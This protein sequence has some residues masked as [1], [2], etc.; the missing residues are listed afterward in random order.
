MEREGVAVRPGLEFDS[1]FPAP[2][3]EDSSV[4]QN[5]GVEDTMQLII[6]TVPQTLWH[7]EKIA[8]RLKGKDLYSTCRNIWNFVYQHIKYKRDKDG[9]EQVRSPRRTWWERKTGVDCDCYTEF[10]S[11]ILYNL[12]IPHV[13][14]ITKY[15]KVSPEVPTW[16]HVY[17]VVPKSGNL[18]DTNYRDGYIVLDCV[19][20][21]F[22]DE[23]PFYEK[24]DYKMR[25]DYLDGFDDEEQ[26]VEVT[27]EYE[28]DRDHEYETVE[29]Q[30]IAAL[31]GDLGFLK[32]L[33]KKVGS[34]VKKTA[35]KVGT[36]VKKAAKVVAD[37]AGDVIR[38]VNR[39]VNPVTILLRNGFLLIMK[40]N[41]FNIAGR[42]RYAYLSDA[43]ATAMN[44]NLANL[45]KLR[46]I[47][48]KAETVYWQAGG[49]KENLKK[50][51]L[52][53]KGNKDK[54]VQL[55]GL[56]GIDDVYMDMDEYNI[57]HADPDNLQGLGE[58]A[59]G[60]AIAAATSAAAAIAAALKQ[61]KGLFNKGGSEEAAFQ[62]ETDNAG[63]ADANMVI[64]EDEEA[65]TIM[66]D[67][68]V[69]ATTTNTN[70]S[71]L[72]PQPTVPTS[73]I[74]R[75]S[76]DLDTSTPGASVPATKADQSTKGFLEKATTWVKDNPGK[77]LLAAG[78]VA[79]GGYLLV[80]ASQSGKSKANGNGLSGLPG[81]R[82]T[83]KRKK[84]RK[85]SKKIQ[86]ITL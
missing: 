17:P 53:G 56:F 81:K 16:Q 54:K 35:S 47:K 15:P 74:A 86:S 50:A 85:S 76:E 40:L 39:F 45:K 66:Q 9:V 12:G 64:P 1:M 38:V 57:I 5:A 59:S 28:E 36:A 70:S 23:Q 10:I 29:A 42:L 4:K 33:V 24:K 58:V 72:S 30:E 31:Y 73:L 51:I 61:I 78:V 69:P 34:A 41:M 32:K 8:K 21:A 84:A 20:N 63:S 75:R 2:S 83:K 79:A 3:G 65:L 62:S 19:K 11:S 14:R 25:L 43:Q 82:K 67:Y 71:S 6:R 44:M 27:Y 77:T 22:D 46:S 68:N 55:S 37:K 52:S 48:D 60:T 80:R 26:E 13:A 49:K 7:T 18:N